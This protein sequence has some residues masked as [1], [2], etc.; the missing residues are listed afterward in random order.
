MQNTAPILREVRTREIT[1]SIQTETFYIKTTSDNVQ[2]FMTR[3]TV[4]N[5]K[6]EVEEVNWNAYGTYEDAPA[7]DWCLLLTTSEFNT[8]RDFIE[9]VE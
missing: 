1:T 7:I 3:E 8:Y 4:V 5:H 9:G 6:G 2:V